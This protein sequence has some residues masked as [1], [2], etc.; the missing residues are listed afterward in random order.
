MNIDKNQHCEQDNHM[1]CDL[2][3]V[4][5]YERICSIFLLEQELSQSWHCRS[6]AA[7]GAVE[8]SSSVLILGH[9]F[10]VKN[11]TAGQHYDLQESLLAEW[12]QL[13]GRI[14]KQQQI[15]MKLTSLPCMV[16]SSSEQMAQMASL[17]NTLEPAGE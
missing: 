12:L 7:H 11:V 8:R 17:A 14:V 10:S 16:S 13:V 5:D 2:K 3:R 4:L 15:K 6:I 9:A 1:F